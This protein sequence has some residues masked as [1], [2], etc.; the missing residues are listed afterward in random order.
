MVYTFSKSNNAAAVKPGGDY[1]IKKEFADGVEEDPW[2]PKEEDP[3]P[4]VVC[5]EWDYWSINA[6]ELKC[7]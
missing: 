3:L 1:N 7:T 5:L 4:V 2:H 6:H